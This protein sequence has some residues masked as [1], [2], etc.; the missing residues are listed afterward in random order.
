MKAPLILIATASLASMAALVPVDTASAQ[1]GGI[2]MDIFGDQKC[3]ESNG[4]EIVV[5]RRLPAYE[6]YRIPKDLRDA[7]K[8]APTPNWTARALNLEYVGRNGPSTCT[9]AASGSETG[10]WS[11]L[12]KEARA[13]RKEKQAEEDKV[14]AALP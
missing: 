7:A 2:V 1:R 11:K 4:E 9:P 10:C 12:M 14:Q 6:Q 3:P 13:E 5:C 8:D